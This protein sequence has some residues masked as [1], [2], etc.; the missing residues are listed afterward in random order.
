MPQFRNPYERGN[1]FIKFDVK[2]P[3]N[4]FADEDTIKVNL[5][6]VTFLVSQS[7]LS[8]SL[9][10]RGYADEWYPS[11]HFPSAIV[12]LWQK[13]IEA[14]LPPRPKIEIPT[15]VEGEDTMVEEVNMDDYVATRREE[16]GSRG[17]QAY[18]EVN[19][20]SFFLPFSVLPLLCLFFSS[21]RI[22]FCGSPQYLLIYRRTTTTMKMDGMAVPV[23]NAPVNRTNIA[24]VTA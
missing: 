12:V 21:C 3:E 9:V 23:F 14:L 24:F 15:E 11:F 13:K 6:W 16:G 20:F 2:F 7:Q 8:L 17:G 5:R 1:L 4:H 10:N 22:W 19:Y 18:Q